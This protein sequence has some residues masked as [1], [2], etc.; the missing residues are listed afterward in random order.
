VE[1]TD[2]SRVDNREC[3]ERK[4]DFFFGGCASHHRHLQ[5]HEQQQQFSAKLKSKKKSMLVPRGRLGENQKKRFGQR[6]NVVVVIHPAVL[7]HF[8]LKFTTK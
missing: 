1:E 8:F 7:V 2:D 3:E 4:L 5:A 6:A